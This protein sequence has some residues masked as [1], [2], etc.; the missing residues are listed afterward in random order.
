MKSHLDI[1]EYKP[2]E[3][4]H[5]RKDIKNVGKTAREWFAL[6][7]R[8]AYDT[9][10]NQILTSS[11][12]QTNQNLVS[13][14]HRIDNLQ[15]AQITPLITF[16]PGFPDG[17]YGWNKVD[18]I[19]ETD[20]ARLF[21]EYVG[22]GDSDKPDN[23]PYSTM[24]R[25]NLLEA[26]WAHYQI[27]ETIL[28]TFDYSSLVAL[29]LLSRHIERRAN[30]GVTKILQVIMI[31]G[32]YYADGHS[33]PFMTTPLLKTS[34]GK[35]GT[36]AAQ[37]SKFIFNQMMQGLWSKEYQVSKTELGEIFEVITRRNGAAFMSNAAG[38]VDE[39]Q[40]NAERWNLSRIF[41]ATY[42]DVSFHILG[43]KEDQFEPNQ[44]KLA[45]ERL[46]AYKPDI[47]LLPGGHMTT[48]EYPDLLANIIH[49]L[50]S[51]L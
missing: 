42:P 18:E 8:I 4:N 7:E 41:K 25:A 30:V 31:N 40:A 9:L 2:S 26:L 47:R 39:H 33:H 49:E 6:G 21:V 15:N 10:H 16:M 35:M 36:W 19:L 5:Q 23:Y 20:K 50:T 22:Q 1:V 45:Q 38:F 24:E 29:E 32:G 43:S 11:D 12:V 13:V 37:R 34:M 28:V 17:S 48:S 46:S 3:L 44:V 27:K 51:T 14:F